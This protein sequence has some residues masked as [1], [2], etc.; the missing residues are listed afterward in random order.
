MATGWFMKGVH[1]GGAEAASTLH[2]PPCG[3]AG[4]DEPCGSQDALGM[5]M[6]RPL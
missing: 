4:G 2:P 1:A 6:E 5:T 3:T